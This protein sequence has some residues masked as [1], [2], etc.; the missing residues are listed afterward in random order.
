MKMEVSMIIS[1]NIKTTYSFMSSIIEIDD[2]INYAKKHNLDYLFISDNNMYG[3]MEFITKCQSNNIK[4]IVG[5]DFNN[6]IL[7]AKNYLGYQNLMKLVTLKSTK[8]I[9]NDDL[10][11]YKNDLICL[12][13]NEDASIQYKDIFDDI[14]ASSNIDSSLK[15]I[16]S[17]A[18]LCLDKTILFI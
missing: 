9:T 14:Y 15:K 18:I 8:E 2:L 3:T 16:D 6:Y 13:L 11:K 17:R 12:I 4:P 5:V 10:S 1:P 7:Y